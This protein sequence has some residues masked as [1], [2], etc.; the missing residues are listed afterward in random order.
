VAVRK[1]KAEQKRDVFFLDSRSV[2]AVPWNSLPN[3]GVFAVYTDLPGPRT[4]GAVRLFT[5]TGVEELRERFEQF[6]SKRMLPFRVFVETAPSESDL[7]DYEYEDF[8]RSILAGIERIKARGDKATVRRVRAALESNGGRPGPKVDPQQNAWL[9]A[10]LKELA[11][12][13]P[14]KQVTLPRPR[15][16]ASV[17]AMVSRFCWNFYLL[18]TLLGA[19]SPSEWQANRVAV[20]IRERFGFSFPDDLVAAQ[21]ALRRGEKQLTPEEHDRNLALVASAQYKFRQL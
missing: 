21:E 12:G 4:G 8:V 6:Q 17:S 10:V 3:R 20:T 5:A 16:P 2:E 9:I 15:K 1:S 14:L 19:N 13:K 11:T 7:T 18:C